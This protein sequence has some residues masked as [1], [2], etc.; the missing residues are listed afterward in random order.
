MRAR[1][2][3]MAAGPGRG[4]GG[5]LCARRDGRGDRQAASGG[6]RQAGGERPGRAVRD[7]LS[8]RSLEGRLRSRSKG[9]FRCAVGT[10]GQCSG[11]VTITG[12]TVRPRVAK[13]DVACFE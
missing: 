6:G 4:G 8:A 13:V 1:I 10:S 3:C 2:V 7:Q 5:E 11:A 9:G 12:T